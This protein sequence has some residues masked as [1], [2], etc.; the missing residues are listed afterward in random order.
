MRKTLF[1]SSFLFMLAL[2]AEMM[3]C[4]QYGLIVQLERPS[5]W[6]QRIESISSLPSI[7]KRRK[8]LLLMKE[9]HSESFERIKPYLNS[10][11]NSGLISVARHMPVGNSVMFKVANRNIAEQIRQIPG[12]I[13]I[14]WD[15][16]E[17]F[18]CEDFAVADITEIVWNLTKIGAPSCWSQGYY[19]QYTIISILDTGV[20]YTH[21]DLA[22]HIW[23]NTGEI[24]GNSADD[25]GNGYVDDYYGYDFANN[26]GDP[27]DD[28]ATTYHG[29]HCAGT[30]AGDGTGTS[31]TGVAPDAMI[32]AVKI[33][34]A[35]GTGQPSWWNAGV[36]YS[37]E[38]G[39]N[40]LSMS[41]GWPNPDS[42]I[43]NYTR[44]VMADILAAGAIAA[45]ATG[46]EDNSYGAPQN[47]SS[48]ADSP[49]PWGTGNRTA[50]VAVGATDASDSIASLSS[51]GPTAWQ[52]GTYNDWPY[53]PGLMKPDVSAPGVGIKSANGINNTS[54]QLL[55][56]TSTAAPH[57][58]GSF[59]VMLSKNPALTPRELDSLLQTTAKDLGEVGKDAK[60]GS[61][62]I[63]LDTAVARTPLP[64][65]PLIK[66][67]NYT[68]ASDGNSNGIA[69]PGETVGL[70]VR[71]INIGAPATNVQ[72]QM[73]SLSPYL[74]ISDGTAGYGGISTGEVKSNLDDLTADI[75][76]S[77]PA[78]T[79]CP[80]RVYITATGGYLWDDT[81]NLAVANYPRQI[82]DLDTGSVTLTIS[83]FGEL[84]FFDPTVSSPQGS[85]FVYGGYNYLFGGG[86]FLGRAF[87]DVVTGE[88]GT[89]S[90]FKPVSDIRIPA[91]T[92]AD[93]ELETKFVTPEGNIQI[94]LRGYAWR[95]SPDNRYVI[96]RYKVKN[97]S[98]SPISSLY[99]GVYLDFDIDLTGSTWY[100]RAQWNSTDGVA[101]M[102][103][104]KSPPSYP[105]YVGIAWVTPAADRGS[106]VHNPTYVW[107]GWADTVKY[108]F[109][110]GAISQISASS[111]DD[112]SVI[113]AWGPFSLSVGQERTYACAI[114]AGD[115]ASNIA[116]IAQQSRTHT[117]EI[118]FTSE[119]N[120]RKPTILISAFPNPFNSTC[121]IQYYIEK[122]G[123][124]EIF[125]IT[126]RKAFERKL[127]GGTNKVSLNS[128]NFTS[129]LYFAVI[130]CNG[131][132]KS[133]PIVVV[134]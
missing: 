65:Q 24:E 48:P 39:A 36:E 28:N 118:L 73:Y 133:A 130:T 4:E 63:R 25:D 14:L 116:S 103:D 107:A 74:T 30:A 80:I 38:M 79:L 108:K 93:Q 109:L 49:S 96:L 2:A 51:R 120:E 98:T 64:T 113:V 37:L 69:D 121:I 13:G 117:D 83:N 47:I 81:F 129:G 131:L 55:S 27:M 95:N 94:S 102:W 87:N 6:Q 43:K 100:D 32:M 16:P 10:L 70:S 29:T 50:S 54:Y 66:Y 85:G 75:S 128:E 45:V 23:T 111:N 91:F 5:W 82:A 68:I 34:N 15:E 46:N 56:G 97:T 125:D 52:T 41:L 77:A 58:A 114:I 101:Y 67:H 59:A 9:A 112:W 132:K 84:G 104:N 71:L 127:N 19:G 122:E 7:D 119:I 72:L 18:I 110:S 53:P 106:I 99:L 78:G 88:G 134:K 40:I 60:F 126:G 123:T 90:E 35:S 3:P 22:D 20:R 1:L 115:N 8:A 89:Q 76:A 31:Q 57:V 12:V 92:T 44:A 26:D 62:R 21:V 17:L 42:D 61:G 11:F 124:L 105:A 86:V 33:M